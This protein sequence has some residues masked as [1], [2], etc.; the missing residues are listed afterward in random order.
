[1]VR[2]DRQ[3]ETGRDRRRV[4]GLV[5]LVLA[6]FFAHTQAEGPATLEP[7]P[8][9]AVSPRDWPRLHLPDP[10][11]FQVA[12]KAL[13]LAWVRLAGVDCGGVLN[14][15]VDGSGRPL[16][17]RLRELAVDRQTYLTM[18]VFIDGSREVPCIKGSFAFTTPG[19]RV[20]RLCVEELKRTWDKRPEHVV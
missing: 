16:N 7:E 19:S 3:P 8:S 18:L 2:T 4:L 20:V 10:V 14:A 5:P 12:L 17:E 15:F 6:A 1:M 13:N 11:G 9:Q